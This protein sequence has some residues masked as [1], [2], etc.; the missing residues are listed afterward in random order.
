MDAYLDAALRMASIFTGRGAIK[1]VSA[2]VSENLRRSGKYSLSRIE[3]PL[4]AGN[5]FDGKF[6]MATTVMEGQHLFLFPFAY[7][8]PH[9]HGE[10]R[11][12]NFTTS[13]IRDSGGHF[14]VLRAIVLSRAPKW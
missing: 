11:S 7:M 3:S 5:L 14:S 9:G 10:S 1:I 2:W 6:S 12:I 8:P 4:R 13:V